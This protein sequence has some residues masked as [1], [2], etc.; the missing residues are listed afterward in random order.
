MKCLD[1]P[2]CQRNLSSII[3]GRE[4]LKLAEAKKT[5]DAKFS[6]AVVKQ[7]T[8]AKTLNAFFTGCI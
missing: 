6:D 1:L 4:I 7:Q 2:A 3:L 5:S 8:G